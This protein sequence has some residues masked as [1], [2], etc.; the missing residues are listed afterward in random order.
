MSAA[1]VSELKATRRWAAFDILARQ[2]NRVFMSIA[3]RRLVNEGA[4]AA[5]AFLRGGRQAALDAVRDSVWVDYLVRLWLTVVA[6]AGESAAAVFDIETAP[7]ALDWA[8]AEY[9][10]RN[11]AERGAG[12]ASTSRAHV[13]RSIERAA[14]EDPGMEPAAISKRI[15]SD[16]VAAARWR[17]ATIGMTEV[18]AASCFAAWTVASAR[19]GTVKIWSK[20]RNRSITCDQHKSAAGE[21]RPVGDAFLIRNDYEPSAG[22][23]R[24]MYPG[25]GEL[26]ARASN[27]I[28]CRCTIDFE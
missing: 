11:S 6:G 17:S 4:G 21:R 19:R 15:Y 12:I 7:A 13:A 2:N 9:N 16:A 24:M 23:D 28:N 3:G 5:A 14:G 8:A 27:V 10:R 20:P 18:H 1:A 22:A 25:D 26:G